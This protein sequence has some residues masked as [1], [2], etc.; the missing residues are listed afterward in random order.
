MYAKASSGDGMFASS[1]LSRWLKSS[2]ELNKGSTPNCVAVDRCPPRAIY[3]AMASSTVGIC[4][5]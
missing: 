5:V 4:P 2:G 3:D 1:S